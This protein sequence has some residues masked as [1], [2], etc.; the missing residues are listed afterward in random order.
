MD[1]PC[2]SCWSGSL[3]YWC[4]WCLHVS[5]LDF[6]IAI[7]CKAE[8]ELNENKKCPVGV[9]LWVLRIPTEPA[10][11]IRRAASYEHAGKKE[12]QTD[13]HPPSQE[14][15]S[16]SFWSKMHLCLNLTGKLRE[17]LYVIPKVISSTVTATGAMATAC[18]L[19]KIASISQ[20]TSIRSSQWIRRW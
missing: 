16:L 17:N 2:G 1:S 3:G 9:I 7:T 19:Q 14:E 4:P 6:L 15:P 8:D 10:S 5:R 12:V 13:L 11:E 20:T 18:R